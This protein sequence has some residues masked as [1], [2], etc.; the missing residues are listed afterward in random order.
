LEHNRVAG[1]L[2]MAPVQFARAESDVADQLK[3]ASAPAKIVMGETVYVPIYSHIYVSNAGKRY[4]AATLSIRNT[5]RKRPIVVTEVRYYD[6]D[7]KPVQTFLDSP[8]TL[9]PL[10]SVDF[11]IDQV[12]KR[13][14]A[15]A[16]F[17]VSWVAGQSVTKPIIETVMAGITG[18]QG[19]A[20]V[21]PG[22]VI[23][24]QP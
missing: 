13:G 6:T 19:I 7:G 9:G 21:P 10:A 5:D 15:G 14:G 20:F 17:I 23:A 24:T 8:H 3:P 22:K 16:N 1:G 18:T 2:I 4:L 12:D 11:V